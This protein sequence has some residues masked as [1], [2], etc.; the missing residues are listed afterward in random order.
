MTNLV[1]KVGYDDDSLLVKAQELAER[2]HLEIDNHFLPRLQVTPKNLELHVQGFKPLSANFNSTHIQKRKQ[3]GKSLGL[4]RACTPTPGRRI[5]DAT[6]GWGRDA[7]ILAHFGASVCMIERNP[8]MFE[9][10][11]DALINLS[12]SSMIKSNL[13][14]IFADAID[15]IE[16]LTEEQLPDV[17]YLDPMHPTRTKSALVKKEMQVLQKLIGEDID[18]KVLL[19]SALQKTKESVVVKWPEKL[20]PI[21]IPHYSVQ[22]KTIRFDI[23]RP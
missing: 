10:L 15:F 3:A 17:I 1:L 5:L 9:L 13:S 14:L 6:A 8:M 11:H 20:P 7:A 18:F 16:N 23:Y 21:F 2:L 19:Q 22:G 4:I 12:N